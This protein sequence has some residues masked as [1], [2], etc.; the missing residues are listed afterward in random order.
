[1][2]GLLFCSCFCSEH[3]GFVVVHCDREAAPEVGILD[4]DDAGWDALQ[5]LT[6]LVCCL[7]AGGSEVEILKGG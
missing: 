7:V 4:H 3:G 2:L 1:M 5:N 6:A